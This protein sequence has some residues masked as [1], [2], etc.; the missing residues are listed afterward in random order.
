MKRR[1]RIDNTPTSDTRPSTNQSVTSIGRRRPRTVDDDT[2]RYAC[3]RSYLVRSLNRNVKPKQ[4]GSNSDKDTNLGSD[5]SYVLSFTFLCFGVTCVH[6]G[7]F[8]CLSG[9]MDA[10]WHCP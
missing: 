2:R 10:Q 7:T 3:Q 9:I 6:K 5:F 1:T 4:T 8:N